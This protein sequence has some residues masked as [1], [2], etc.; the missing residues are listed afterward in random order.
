MRREDPHEVPT[1]P[2]SP[3]VC[4]VGEMENEDF[5]EIE[6]EEQVRE[7]ARPPEV[8]RD[9]GAPTAKELEEHNTTHLPFRSWCPHCVAGKAQD[10]PHKRQKGAQMDKQLP[11]VVFDYGFFGGEG[12]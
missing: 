6:C 2:V 1:I 8:L 5:A 3:V 12:R 4:E 7:E 9:P 11:E 10:R